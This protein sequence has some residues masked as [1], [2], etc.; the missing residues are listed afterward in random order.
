MFV[1][2]NN[3]K[4][5]VAEE[6]E[7]RIR[8]IGTL[9]C[10]RNFNPEKIIHDNH[11]KTTKE[12]NWYNN[13]T[14]GRTVYYYIVLWYAEFFNIKSM[15]QKLKSIPEVE[16]LRIVEAV[17][18]IIREDIQSSWKQ[19]LSIPSEKIDDVNVELSKTLLRCLT[20][21]IIKIHGNYNLKPDLIYLPL[22]YILQLCRLNYGTISSSK[23]RLWA[24]T[25]K[26]I[27]IFFVNIEKVP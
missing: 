25:P 11:F 24:T 21:V 18:A 13:Y 10:H 7:T 20:E 3:S 8:V 12:F 4:R 6:G 2:W 14:K 9:C 23:Y 15:I 19:G 5:L 17:A 27:Y 16:R 26:F 1:I 22:I